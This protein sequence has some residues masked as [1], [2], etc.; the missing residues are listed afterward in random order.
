MTFSVECQ[1]RN[2]REEE[3]MPEYVEAVR[4]WVKR[5]QSRKITVKTALGIAGG[6]L[7]AALAWGVPAAAQTSAGGSPSY[8][9]SGELI[10]PS[11][12][13]EW[14][15]VTS[16]L[17]MTYGPAPAAGEQTPMFDNVFV[18]PEAYREFL[19]SGTWPD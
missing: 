11:D 2:P 10:R 18:G 7:A 5:K 19:R 13:R 3:K 15:Y 8:S 1:K 9:A 14:V 12:Y 16:G 6:A 17:G 4:P